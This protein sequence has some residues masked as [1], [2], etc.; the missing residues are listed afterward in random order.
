ML[1]VTGMSIGQDLRFAIRMLL[2]SPATTGLALATQALG[3]GIT[4]T[5]F[6]LVDALYLRPLDVRQPDELAYGFQTYKGIYRELSMVDY[7]HY[8]DHA[9]SFAALAAYYPYSPMHVQA[10]SEP[11]EITGGVTTANVFPLLRLTPQLGRFFAESED[12]VPDRD[13]VTVISDH[14]WRARLGA[15]PQVIGK[16]IQVN[17]RAFTIVGVAPRNFEGVER[18]GGLIELWIPSAMFATGYR[19]CDALNSRTCRTVHMI[20]RLNPDVSIAEA[21]AEFAVLGQQLSRAYPDLQVITEGIQLVAA[22]GSNAREPNRET[23]LVRLL[24]GGVAMLVLIACANIGGL[25]LARGSARRKEVTI[26]LALGA[27][28]LRVVRQFL[29]E[30]FV[31]AVLGAVLGIIVA[32]WGIDFVTNF[33]RVDYAGRLSMFDMSIRWPVLLATLLVTATTAVLFGLAPALQAARTNALPV[34]KEES[35]SAGRPRTFGRNALVVLQVAMSI[36]LL[37]SAALLVRSVSALYGGTGVDPDRIALLRLRP[38]LVGHDMA[39]ARAFQ[40]TVIERF[41]QLPE[42]EAVAAAENVPLMGYGGEVP[43]KPMGDAG[44]PQG[45]TAHASF[46]GDGYFAVIGVPLLAGR[47]FNSSDEVAGA[48]RV[49]IV[50]ELVAA[51]LGGVSQSVGKTVSIDGDPFRIVGVAPVAQYHNVEHPVFP[52]VYYNY[53]QETGDNFMADSRMHV[54][55]RG[56]NAAAMLPALR[57]IVTSVDPSVPVNEDYGMS[58]RVTFEFQRVRI[59][60]TMLAGFGVFALVLCAIG[61]Y[62]VVAFVAHMRTREIAIRVALGADRSHVRRMIVGDGLRLAI[63]GAIL[64]I[65]ASFGASQFLG[66]LLYG[67]DPHDPTVFGSISLLLI[68]VSLIASYIPL[69]G[70]SRIDPSVA[71]RDQ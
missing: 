52:Y 28:R 12:T 10:G 16:S 66:S 29:I 40:R 3:I 31:L 43:V 13:A 59:A 34:L 64:G 42:V 71:L 58:D 19:Y 61:V 57:R 6:S 49:A 69:R 36:V 53:W 2:K 47:D 67:V 62:G 18:G 24:L 39:R 65:A 25:L 32:Q 14:L 50:D 22:R 68:T 7:H 46:V 45:T 37:I 33:Y 9:K 26:R 41:K 27:G 1:W 15:D 44:G 38:S 8:R 54:R 11:F 70:A 17:G 51:S 56:G 23:N 20:G 30:S 48:P 21:Q 55:M 5:L 63:P 60:M 35:A 4:V